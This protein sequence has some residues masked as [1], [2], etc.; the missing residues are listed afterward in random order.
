M[1]TIGEK[2]ERVKT[3]PGLGRDVTAFV[4]MVVAGIVGVVL[5]QGALANGGPFESRKDVKVEFAAINGMNPDSQP[6]VTIAGVVVGYVEDAETTDHGTA[7]VTL[8]MEAQYPVHTN[9][10]AILR[11]KN[12]LNDMQVEVNPGGP[13][14]PELADG[15]VIPAAQTERPVQADEVLQHVDERTQTALTS[16]LSESDTA[17]MHASQQLPGGLGATSST[18]QRLQ[19]V[20]DALKTRRENIRALV[21]SLAQI[22]AAAGHDDSRL[23]RLAD[24]TQRTLTSLAGNDD[25]LRASLDQLP[26]LGNQ[27]R[28]ALQGTQRLTQQLNPTLDDLHQASDA[29][30]P[31]LDELRGTADKLGKTVDAAAP[32][33]DKAQPVVGDLRPVVDDVHDSLGTLEPVTGRLDRDTGIVTSYLTE[34][35]AFIYNTRSVFGAGDAQGGIIRGHVVVP[36]GAFVVPQQPGYAPGP[37]AASHSD[38]REGKPQ[39]G[40]PLNSIM[41]GTR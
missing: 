33:V 27:V 6:K 8:N 18:L 24:S 26:D 19:P 34:L 10:R 11:P 28:D 35:R 16:L 9:A 20:T 22:S 32:V 23:A 4:A 25:A 15:A 31:A 7:V 3:T 38:D 29:L 39:Q 12:P 36:T 21:T 1:S 14:A 40:G 2:W 17:L 13:P 30:P 41:G 5:I 37:Q